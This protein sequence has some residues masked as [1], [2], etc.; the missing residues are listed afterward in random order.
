MSRR[1]ILATTL[2]SLL[3][4]TATTASAELRK[5]KEGKDFSYDVY[6]P[7]GYTTAHSWPLLVLFHWS[8]ARSTNMLKLWK[9]T[10]DKYGIV[11][12]APNSQYWLT[13]TKHDAARTQQMIVDLTSD[14][15]IDHDRIFAS[16]FSA[17]ANFTYRMMATNPGLFRAVGPFAG[18]LDATEGEL[19]NPAGSDN[20]RVCISH[21]TVDHKIHFGQAIKAQNRLESHGFEVRLS[22]FPQGHW[23]PPGYADGMWRCLSGIAPDKR[24]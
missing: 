2:V 1:L 4:G 5:V 22:K 13:W 19:G 9:D 20:T 16:G 3:C 23:L 10:A 6:L 7:E 17:G 15:A 8:T 14:L 12:A 18:F 11:L 21:G 24:S